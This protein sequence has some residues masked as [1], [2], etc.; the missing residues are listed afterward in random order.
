MKNYFII[1][2]LLICSYSREIVSAQSTIPDFKAVWAAGQ[3]ISLKS[4]TW[5]EQGTTEQYNQTSSTWARY[6]AGILPELFRE[7]IGSI[8]DGNALIQVGKATYTFKK[9]KQ[10]YSGWPIVHFED[11]VFIKMSIQSFDSVKSDFKKIGIDLAKGRQQVWNGRTTLIF[12]ASHPLDEDTDQV[13]YDAIEKYPVRWRYD[14]R[15]GPVDIQYSGYKKIDGVW[16]PAQRKE[17]VNKKLHQVVQYER[18]RFNLHLDPEIF[19][20]GQFGSAHWLN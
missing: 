13:W 4:Y 20:P 9:Y 1:A 19:D 10:A 12:G 2:L 11:L 7:D 14:S 3:Q 8:D 15:S 18:V 17:Y 6:K 16:F 5:S